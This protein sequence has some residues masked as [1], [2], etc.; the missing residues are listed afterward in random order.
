MNT[1]LARLRAWP[2]TP[3]LL[4]TL[5][6]ALAP[7]TDRPG[8]E[9]ATEARGDACAVT[10]ASIGWGF[11][12]AF[13]SYISGTIAKGEWTVAEGATYETPLFGFPA[14]AGTYDGATGEGELSFPGAITF[15]GHGGVLNTT[16]RNPRIELEGDTG[17]LF[18]DVSGDTQAG[19]AVDRAGVHF[20]DLDF[21]AATFNT[22]GGRM[23]IADAPAALT[24]QGSAAFGTYEPGSELDPLTIE[25][26]P[27]QGCEREPA[28]AADEPGSEESRESSGASWLPWAVGGA[29]VLVVVAGALALLRRRAPGA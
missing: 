5:A 23:T 7:L 22:A 13:R 26:T 20:A 14:G 16:V 15:T 25:L 17:R 9:V 1:A 2:S 11:K 10:E 6:L 12:E 3:A 8:D 24:E 18:L 19:E 27:A 28:P 4:L 21:A 29:L